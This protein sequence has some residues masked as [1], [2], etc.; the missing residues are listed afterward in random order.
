MMKKGFLLLFLY[1]GVVFSQ[2]QEQ[3]QYTVDFNY[4]YGSI[5]PH[6]NKITHLITHH[7]EGVFV[8][9]NRKTFGQKEWHARFNYPDY[10][11]GFNYQN[12]KN[13]NLGDLYGLY[14]HYSFYFLERR[15]QLKIA[16][17]VSYAS[18]PYHKEKNYRNVAYGSWLMP[19][20]YFMLNYHYEN[21]WRGIG[22]QAG[23]FLLHHSNATLRAPNTST[24]T[25]GF[26]V[27][28]NYKF[29][30]K[31]EPDYILPTP[32]TTRFFEPYHV[33]LAF[34]TGVHENKINSG[35]YPFYNISAYVDKQIT[36]S[37]GFQL[38]AELML[39]R[40][41]KRQIAMMVNSF[42]EQNIKEGTDYK[43][44][45]IFAGYELFINKLSFNAQLAWYAYNKYPEDQALYER[46]ALNYYFTDKIFATAGLKTHFSKA[47]ALEFG[48]GIRI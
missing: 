11:V 17:G 31:N 10:G 9:V 40:M 44:I 46:L 5:L 24:N 29:D 23:G 33:N 35:R 15:L 27:G 20:T 1:C 13:E 14:L 18:N 39:S 42:P 2:E 32:D 36:K 22:F 43:R 38:G 16:Q 25:V 4:Y 26:N 45:G 30:Y 3:P 12:N 21:I 34:R 19:S 28:L 37:S 7:P 6:S 41:R 47:E 8:N 48:V